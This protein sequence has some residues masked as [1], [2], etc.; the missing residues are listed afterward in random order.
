MVQSNKMIAKLDSMNGDEP[1]RDF[2]K[3][4][5]LSTT[6]QNSPGINIP[7]NTQNVQGMNM[8]QNNMGFNQQQGPL[9][10]SPNL[11]MQPMGPLQNNMSPIQINLTGS[12][13][14]VSNPNIGNPNMSSNP[15]IG[16]QN[17][18]SPNMINNPNMNSP[19][20]NSPGN[21]NMLQPTN[22][23][24]NGQQPSQYP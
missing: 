14:M 3:N 13:N 16:T 23:K 1:V 10:N 20:M 4:R 18:G 21:P 6:S 11:Q 5:N 15:N 9:I 2:K 24:L 22:N 7:Q 12:P 19:N 8:G 17:M